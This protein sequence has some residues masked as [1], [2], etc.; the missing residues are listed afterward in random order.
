[1]LVLGRINCTAYHDA[2]ARLQLQTER[3][4]QEESSVPVRCG[5]GATWQLQCGL[6]AFARLLDRATAYLRAAILAYPV[7]YCYRTSCSSRTAITEPGLGI[8][9]FGCLA[10]YHAQTDYQAADAVVT[11]F[12]APSELCSLIVTPLMVGG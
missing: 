5:A 9:M 4:R 7:D 11:T 2:T 6:D 3:T 1:L 10:N 12:L 8:R